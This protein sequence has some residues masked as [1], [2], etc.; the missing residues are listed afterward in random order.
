MTHDKSVK[1][2]ADAIGVKIQQ[3]SPILEAFGNAKTKNNDNSSRFG[4][5][6]KLQFDMHGII[7]GAVTENCKLNTITYSLEF[8][9]LNRF[10]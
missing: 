9:I 4:K 6:I 8:T 3:A 2:A 1:E 7:K 5:F 10:T